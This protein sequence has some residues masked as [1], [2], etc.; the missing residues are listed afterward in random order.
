MLA[1]AL[2]L[3]AASCSGSGLGLGGEV[4]GD[5]RDAIT[6]ALV[7]PAPEAIDV[8][9]ATTLQGST[10][11]V[12]E[13]DRE[14]VRAAF[15]AWTSGFSG[16]NVAFADSASGAEITVQFASQAAGVPIARTSVDAAPSGTEIEAATILFIVEPAPHDLDLTALHEVGRAL[17]MVEGT[18]PNAFDVMSGQPNLIDAPSARDLAT[19]EAIYDEQG[20]SI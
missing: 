8:Y 9:I 2:S 15:R 3:A 16:M 5:Y 10:A 11:A 20:V 18:S 4:E 17:G 7:W 13:A 14:S 1:V 6:T 19:L 12:D